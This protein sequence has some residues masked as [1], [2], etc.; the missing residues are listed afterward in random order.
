MKTFLILLKKEVRELLTP[1]LLIPLV[2]MMIVFSFLGNVLGEESKKSA[3]QNN[4]AILNQDESP[5]TSNIISAA[6]A[7]GFDLEVYKDKSIEEALAQT[8]RSALL[9]FPKG[10][11]KNI[12]KGEVQKLPAYTTLK[13]LAVNS[14]KSS[15]ELS[16]F[17]TIANKL[18]GDTVVKSKAP[19]LDL[20]FAKQ[21]V[22]INNFVRVGDKQANI[23]PSAIAGFIAGQTTFIPIILFLVITI[24]SQ[25]VVVSLAAEKEN[26]TL[27][28]LLSSPVNRKSIVAS[29]L[30]GAGLISLMMA[31]FYLIGM[32]GYMNSITQLTAPA[33]AQTALRPILANLGLIFTGTDYVVL[34]ISLFLGILAALSLAFILGSFAKDVKSGQTVIAPMMILLLIPYL[35]SLTADIAT[36]S[37]ALRVAIYAIPFTHTFLAANNIL[38]GRYL[39]IIL[40]NLYLGV[41]IL[42]SIFIAGKIF[43]S[44]K[45]LTMKISLGKKHT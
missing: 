18:I 42:V 40:G 22:E 26:K 39:P 6:G 3:H 17:V 12:S 25:L 33:D 11:S 19:N 24:A 38:L 23:D 15:S 37:P 32:R 20:D 9:V 36:L 35:L 44:E 34:G 1:Q 31:A 21:P 2:I 14:N 27:E 41:I 7:G 8:Q 10:F 13:S 5:L 45:I 28:T 30:L 16:G 4:I 43:S 29:K